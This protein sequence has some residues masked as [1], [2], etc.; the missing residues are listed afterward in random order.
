[1][2]K[3]LDNLSASLNEEKEQEALTSTLQVKLSQLY[4]KWNE[5]QRAVL[6]ELSRSKK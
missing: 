2:F 6:R 5:F 1:M 3:A 4:L